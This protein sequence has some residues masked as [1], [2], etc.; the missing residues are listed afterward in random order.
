[1][2]ITTHEF[3]SINVGASANDGTGDEL[4][5]AF[6]KVNANFDYISNTGVTTGNISAT[7]IE[8]TSLTT[9]ANV[10]ANGVSAGN[11]RT[12]TLDA[13]TLNSTNISATANVTADGATVG[14]IF[15]AGSAD[16]N[17]VN[18][19]SLNTTGNV[20]FA[21]SYVPVTAVDG[22][23]AGQI[24]YDADYVYICVATDS[25]KRANLAAW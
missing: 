7:A 3:T 19:V 17:T 2:T 9:T 21:T 11:V 20:V 8:A 18:S 6:I 15:I 22:G 16:V 14:N 10:T 23:T 1:M 12:T 4:R 25:W 5:T 24:A 13:T